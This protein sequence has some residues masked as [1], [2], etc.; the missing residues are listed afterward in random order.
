VSAVAAA[1]V[2]ETEE[3][4]SDGYPLARMIPPMMAR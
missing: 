3:I 1:A 2:G 4:T